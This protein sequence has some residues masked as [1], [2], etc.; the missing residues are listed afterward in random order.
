M[1]HRVA[2]RKLSR[3]SSH[4]KA[5]FRNQVTSL[6][7]HERIETTVAKAKEL[8]RIAD[9][10]IT[11]GKKQTLVARRRVNGFVM[12]NEASKKVFVD[13]APRFADRCGGYTRVLKTRFRR[14]DCAPMAIIEWSQT[15]RSILT[16][17]QLLRKEQRKTKHRRQSAT[18]P[19]LGV[20]LD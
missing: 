18:P 11:L 14:G 13:L 12:T 9:R 7:E 20:V 6:I 8:R 1:K 3:S 19:G 10:I 5:L 4:R 15:E 16:P 17:E 2:L